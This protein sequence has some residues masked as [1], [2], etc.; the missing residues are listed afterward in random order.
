VGRLRGNGAWMFQDLEKHSNADRKEIPYIEKS[1]L[2]IEG[3]SGLPDPTLR[4]ICLAVFPEAEHR[5]HL[6]SAR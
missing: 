4:S 1:G 5:G 3:E 6:G 2:W